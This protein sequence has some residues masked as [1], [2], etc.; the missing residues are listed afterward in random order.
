MKSVKR[1]LVSDLGNTLIFPRCSVVTKTMAKVLG[2]HGWQGTNT[3]LEPLMRY[4]KRTVIANALHDCVPD[5]DLKGVLEASL[6]DFDD[7]LLEEIEGCNPAEE[8]IPGAVELVE[9]VLSCGGDVGFDTGFSEDTCYL[10]EEVFRNHFDFGSCL[11]F[12]PSAPRPRGDSILY[13]IQKSL[14]NPQ[15]TVKL[16]DTL[17]DMGSG[18]DVEWVMNVALHN[19]KSGLFRRSDLYHAGADL[20]VSSPL[21]ALHL[22]EPKDPERLP[23]FGWRREEHSDWLRWCYSVP[24]SPTSAPKV[25]VHHL[26]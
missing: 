5:K 21:D 12:Y 8:V 24:E 22:F 18:A 2:T 17:A 23:A 1:L 16:G 19:K 13:F 20:I 10:V 25:Q 26:L 6:M 14:N 15:D 3:D 4:S 7:A 11:G 9:G